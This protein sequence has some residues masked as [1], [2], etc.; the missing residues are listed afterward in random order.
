MKKNVNT[1]KT[2]TRNNQ[3]NA[4]EVRNMDVLSYASD[5]EL[6]RLHAHLQEER[7]K[8]SRFSD[9]VTLWEIEICY[10][11]RE[12]RIRST[13]KAAHERYLKTNPDF[14]ADSYATFD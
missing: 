6:E 8:I 5:D 1:N 12:M 11:Q 9:D 7:E 14:Y 13:R 4:P 2:Y 3:I 10:V